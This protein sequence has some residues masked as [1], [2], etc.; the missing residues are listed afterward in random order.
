[1]LPSLSELL[2][3]L[4]IAGF[5]VVVH[6]WLLK[7]SDG[8]RNSEQFDQKSETTFLFEG[9]K[10]IDATHGA[11]RL[12]ENKFGRMSDLEAVYVLFQSDFPRLEEQINELSEDGQIA[13]TSFSDAETRLTIERLQDRIKLTLVGRLEDDEGLLLAKIEDRS[14]RRELADLREIAQSA[15]QLIWQVD[16]TGQVVWCNRA[17]LAFSDRLNDQQE[18]VWPAEPIFPG[19]HEPDPDSKFALRGRHSLTIQS[20]GVEQWFNITSVPSERGTLHFASDANEELRSE[21][22]QKAFIHTFAKTFAQL[23]VGLAIFDKSRHLSMFNP[24]FLDMSGLPTNFLSSRPTID[25]MFNRMRELGRLPEPKDYTAWREQFSKLLDKS[26]TESHHETWALASGQTYRVT[27]RPHP[28]GATALLFEDITAEISLTRRFRNELKTSQAV[29]DSLADSIAVF[30]PA[31]TLIMTNLAY[32][33]LWGEDEGVVSGN[34]LRSAL[35]TWKSKSVPCDIWSEIERSS[36][37]ASNRKPWK[38]QLT[39]R[40]GRHLQCHVAPISGGLT[41]V[42]FSDIQRHR[43]RIS[44]AAAASPCAEVRSSNKTRPKHFANWRFRDWEDDLREEF[45]PT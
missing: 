24:A 44:L 42:K 28:D 3:S 21:Q 34:D 30:S 8:S 14:M 31:Q 15:P 4:L 19:I 32:Q 27:G 6:L 5:L 36:I 41:M 43:P 35:R 39:L 1:M 7:R 29:L 45:Y 40:D 13:I 37:P 9:T 23:S 33:E 17:Y 2:V 26:A 22:A 12:F 16:N 11:D 38:T 10:L 18:N 20:E 25:A